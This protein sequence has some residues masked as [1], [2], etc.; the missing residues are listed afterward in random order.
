MSTVPPSPA[1]ARTRTSS[2]P[3]ARIAAA[4][5][6]ATAAALPNS[7]C[8]HG[9]CHADSGKGVEKT[10]RHPV[11]FTVTRRPP[12]ARIAASITTRAARASPQPRHARW[13]EVIELARSVDDWTVRSL[14]SSEPVAG[15]EGADLVE[16]QRRGGHR[17][18]SVRS[19]GVGKLAGELGGDP[20]LVEVVERERLAA[21]PSGDDV[22]HQ[23]LEDVAR[24]RSATQP[25]DNVVDR[26][27][28][29]GGQAHVLAQDAARAHGD[30]A[31]DDD[32]S[33]HPPQRPAYLV[34]RATAGSRS[35]RGRR[36][37][38]PRR[39]ARRRRRRASR[40]PNP[41][42]RRPRLRPRCGRAEGGRPSRGRTPSAKSSATSL[43]T[44]SA[45]SWR[46]AIRYFTSVKASGPTI[47]PI[48]TGSSGSSHCRA[49]NGGRKASTWSCPGTSISS[50]AWV[51]TKPSMHT[52]TGRESR[53]CQGERLDV[54][55]DGLLVGRREE[56]QPTGV[57][58]RKCVG[59]VVPDVDRRAE[60]T[61]GHGHHHR[62]TRAPTRWAAPR[63]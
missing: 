33:R 21:H 5:P 3:V 53:S 29:G 24:D 31:V 10:S 7:E 48:V 34:Q 27:P 35:P 19:G 6:D 20:F 26:R 56:H 49:R 59:V 52:M 58:L 11:A 2:R 57:A 25:E 16:L 9:T 42:R 46:C 54:Q 32:H 1:C 13:P 17:R 37:R 4:T 44:S 55:V 12:V 41:G 28:A 38:H 45:R 36:P 61:V 43:T 62:Q 60:C 18:S 14:G 39:A 23:A 15:R 30:G 22:E 47:A 8:S 40:A 50:T 63:P 51:S